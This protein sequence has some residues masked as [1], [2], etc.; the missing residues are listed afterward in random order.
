MALYQIGDVIDDELDKRGRL[1]CDG[2]R[3]DEATYPEL[4]AVLGLSEEDGEFYY[5]LP[6]LPPVTHGDITIRPLIQATLED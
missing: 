2:S 6:N 3:V 4:C 5:K 1:E